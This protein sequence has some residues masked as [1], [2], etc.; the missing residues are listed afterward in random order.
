MKLF[1]K[2]LFCFFVSLS[3]FSQESFIVLNDGAK[4]SIQ[5]TSVRIISFENKILYKNINK[6]GEQSI[7]FKDFDYIIYS[8]FKFKAIGLNKRKEKDGYFILA[9]TDNKLLLSKVIMAKPQEEDEEPQ[10]PSFQLLITDNQFNT[11][12]TMLVDDE[13]NSKSSEQRNLIL[14]LIKLNFPNC[15]NLLNRVIDYDK[16]NGDQKNRSILGIFNSPLFIDCK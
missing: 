5:E 4:I 8:N 7:E 11:L 1:Y 3:T 14:P 12:A 10:K 6:S 15:D 9:E 16:K 2:V 13:T